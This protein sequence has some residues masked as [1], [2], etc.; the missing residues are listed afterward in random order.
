MPRLVKGITEFKSTTGSFLTQALFIEQ[1]TFEGKA[2][3]KYTLKNHDHKGFPSLKRLYF[4]IDDPTEYKVATTYFD[5]W[6]HWLHLCELV[7]F[8]PLVTAWR[9]EMAVKRASEGL[10]RVITEIRSGGKSSL[11]AARFLLS[12]GWLSTDSSKKKVGR[13]KKEDV[14]SRA[15]LTDEVEEDARRVL[16]PERVLN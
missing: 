4:E 7:W 10:E 13:P 12:N 11:P 9:A 15:G 2:G 3:V 1:N 14:K 5:G 6:E 16:I 8:K